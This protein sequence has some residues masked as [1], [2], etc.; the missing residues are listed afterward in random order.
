MFGAEKTCCKL[1]DRTTRLTKKP[2]GHTYLINKKGQIILLRNMIL[3]LL[4]HG[5]TLGLRGLARPSL[6]VGE[7]RELCTPGSPLV[8]LAKQRLIDGVAF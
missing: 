2:P 1:A 8:D 5:V 7:W 3:I 6:C 4:T